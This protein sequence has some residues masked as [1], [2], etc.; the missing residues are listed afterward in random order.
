M[1]R[2][3]PRNH[4]VLLHHRPKRSSRNF[5]CPEIKEEDLDYNFNRPNGPVGL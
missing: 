3:I 4:V 5:C 2:Y 1:E